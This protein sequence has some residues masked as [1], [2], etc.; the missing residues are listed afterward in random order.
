MKTEAAEEGASVAAGRGESHGGRPGAHFLLGA[1]LKVQQDVG[2]A[3]EAYRRACELD[4]RDVAMRVD[5][6]L[7]LAENGDVADAI[8]T[9]RIALEMNPDMAHVR[10]RLVELLCDTEA[11]DV[12]RA[13]MDRCREQG[14]TL[15]PDLVDLLA[16][17]SVQRP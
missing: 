4:P 16:S 2:A 3:V 11:Y 15:P 12:A 5:L 9:L 6:G 7:A 14:I 10:V 13:E 8:G 17:D 1:A